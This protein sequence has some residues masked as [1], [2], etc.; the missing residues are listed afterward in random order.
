[1]AR[2]AYWAN[3][4]TGGG[5]G[6]LDAIDGAGL[7]DLD[8]AHVVTASN[9]FEYILD[10]DSGLAENS[11]DI[12]APDTNAGDKRWI[13][14]SINKLTSDLDAGG[15]SIN[16]LS[17]ITGLNYEFSWQLQGAAYVATNLGY[18]L[19][20]PGL[21]NKTIS[22]VKIYSASAPTGDSLIVDVN[23]NGTTI[24]TT[25]G[26]RPEIAIDG[27]S[28]DSGTPDVTSLSEGDK[29][30]FDID[31]VGSTVAGGNPLLVT[32]VFE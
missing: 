31:Q 6:A 7:A 1:M 27:H 11:P 2:N 12:I 24:F 9:V 28:D 22:K 29:L 14:V 20:G 4:L 21:A 17:G 15:N 32:I 8:T 5:T 26:N 30:S 19:V 25:Q 23:K 18:Y 3:A 13:L 16:N 10:A